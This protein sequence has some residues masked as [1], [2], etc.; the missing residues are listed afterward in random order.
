MKISIIIPVFNEQNTIREV[1]DKVL[2]LPIDKEV[3][4]VNDCWSDD[5]EAILKDIRYP[6]LRIIHGI[7]NRGKG[8]AL[9]LGMKHVRGDIVLVQD[10]DF[11][12]DPRD[13]PS[14]VEP[15]MSGRADVVYES[16]FM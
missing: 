10:A 5:T 8:H 6:D 3:V 1:L 12:Y 4:V 11:E 14:L 15:I 9:R 2:A 16:R 13:I 7:E